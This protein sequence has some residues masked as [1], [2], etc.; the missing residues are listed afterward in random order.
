MKMQRSSLGRVLRAVKEDPRRLAACAAGGAVLAG[1][2]IAP[3]LGHSPP[4]AGPRPD[5]GRNVLTLSPECARAHAGDVIELTTNN[6]QRARVILRQQAKSVNEVASETTSAPLGPSA[7]KALCDAQATLLPT[8]GRETGKVAAGAAG[9]EERDLLLDSRSIVSS[10]KVAL[11]ASAGAPEVGRAEQ[12]RID[13]L[14]AKIAGERRNDPR[15]WA[16]DVQDLANAA[17]ALAAGAA[18][19]TAEPD[20]ERLDTGATTPDGMSADAQ[21]KIHVEAVA[22]QRAAHERAAF[23]AALAKKAKRTATSELKAHV[24]GLVRAIYA[25]H[26]GQHG[27]RELDGEIGRAIA[28]AKKLAAAQARTGK[29]DVSAIAKAIEKRVRT[30]PTVRKS[31]VDTNVARYYTPQPDAFEC[32]NYSTYMA[33]RALGVHPSIDHI[34][35]ITKVSATGGHGLPG[36]GDYLADRI[37]RSR[38]PVKATYDAS[39]DARAILA[40]VRQG[41]VA[42]VNGAAVG[43]NGGHFFTIV[44]VTRDGKAIVADPWQ[45]DI[46][47]LGSRWSPSQLDFMSKHGDHPPG[48]V[49]LERLT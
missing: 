46:A 42:I 18:R 21:A 32:S 22:Q 25:P 30:S 1:A 43:S 23:D 28:R 33:M 7:R 38:L 24:G 12:H 3:T 17:D 13:A 15:A 8:I 11:A 16:H 14:I 4:Q 6:G 5:L 45:G 47:S 31:W 41:Y 27:G 34:R 44:G 29:V 36:G 9:A 10:S 19:L 48:F 2:A 40:K 37:N 26:T 35:E 20:Q 49:M 39:A